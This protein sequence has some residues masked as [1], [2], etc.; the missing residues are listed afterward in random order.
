MDIR[1]FKLANDEEIVCEVVDYHD[2][3]DALV[4]R[5]SLRLVSMD[6]LAQ[7]TRYYAFRP[8]M[9]YQLKKDCFQVLSGQHIIAEC[10]PQQELID[11]YFKSLEQF[12]NEDDD[13]DNVSIDEM[14]AEMKAHMEKLNEEAEEAISEYEKTGD[15][16]NILKF[17]PKTTIH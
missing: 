1:Q 15:L 4:I 8:F 2:D 13:I 10:H 16:D 9:M 3:D 7:G 12:L 11:Q 5:K 17:K 6:N 14:R